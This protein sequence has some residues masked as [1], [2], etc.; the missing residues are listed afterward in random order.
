VLSQLARGE[1]H[2]EQQAEPSQLHL[3]THIHSVSEELLRVF[4]GGVLIKGEQSGDD[5]VLVGGPLLLAGQQV[6]LTL[7][8]CRAGQVVIEAEV[9][10]PGPP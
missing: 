3:V 6:T 1:D 7:T 4:S 9:T 8:F 10:V 5:P 2:H